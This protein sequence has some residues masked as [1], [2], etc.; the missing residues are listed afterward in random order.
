VTLV[1]PGSSA[2]AVVVAAQPDDDLE[3]PVFLKRAEP[4]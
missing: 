4:A 1:D 2:P 3:L